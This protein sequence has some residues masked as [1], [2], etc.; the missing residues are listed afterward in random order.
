M[1]DKKK[2]GMPRGQRKSRPIAQSAQVKYKVQDAAKKN[3]IKQLILFFCI[4]Y[5]FEC[6]SPL[7]SRKWRF[8]KLLFNNIGVSLIGMILDLIS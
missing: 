7:I 1:R 3:F 4:V 8:R 5:I 2:D 6:E